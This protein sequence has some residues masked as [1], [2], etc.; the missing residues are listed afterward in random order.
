MMLLAAAKRPRKKIKALRFQA[1][2]QEKQHEYPIDRIPAT[3]AAVAAWPTLLSAESP[4]HDR[5]TITPAFKVTIPNIPGKSLVGLVVTYPPGGATPAH[6]HPRSAFVTGYVLTGSIRSQVEP[7]K[8]QVF[9]ASEHW[10]EP[11]G[12][13]H[14]IHHGRGIRP[15]SRL[16]MQPSP[17]GC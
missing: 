15:N 12:A 6:S 3:L 8:T 5:Q 4:S 1:I 16:R 14:S 17:A 2:T 11:T 10:T 9:H 7:G 13:Y